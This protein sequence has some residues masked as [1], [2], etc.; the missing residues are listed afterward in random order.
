MSLKV[1]EG[2]RREK[3]HEK[4]GL[5]DPSRTRTEKVERKAAPGKG[6]LRLEPG[7]LLGFTLM[8]LLSSS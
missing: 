6:G 3:T 8:N 4:M 5:T 2:K 1:Q 7:A